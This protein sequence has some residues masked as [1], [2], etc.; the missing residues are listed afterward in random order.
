MCI[1]AAAVAGSV[2]SPEIVH[3]QEPAAPAMEVTVTGAPNSAKRRQQSAEAV[4]VVD[5]RRSKQQSADLGEV[6]ARTQ[7]VAVR[8]EGGLGS[9][10]R[11]SLNGLYDQQIRF[12]V[13]GVPLELAGYPFGIANVPL[14]LIDRV[15]VYRGVVPIRFGADALGG[16]VNLVGDDGVW[17]TAGA[18]YQVGSFGTHRTS[19]NARY[20]H[21]P[22]GALLRGAAFLDSTNNDYEID[23]TLA[24]AEGQLSRSTARRFHD[25]YRAYGASLEAG[26]VE[27]PWAKRLLLRV[28]AASYDKELQHNAIMTSP[29]GEVRYGETVY[30]ATLRYDVELGPSVALELVGSYARRRIDYVDRSPWTYDWYGKLVFER[31]GEIDTLP[32]D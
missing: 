13:D 10:A 5:L 25:D 28:F 24:D 23:V 30:G 16:A 12:F 20:Y 2:T 21:Q 7:G 17:P 26:V 8:R 14:N 27:R 1:A 11:F 32:H 3:A 15:E 6:L 19:V 22:S 29:Y 31:P 18:S 9:Q 4:N